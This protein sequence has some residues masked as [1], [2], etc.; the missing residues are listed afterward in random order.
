M[1][2][3]WQILSLFII[4]KVISSNL[5]TKA[6]KKLRNGNLPVEVEKKE[7]CRFSAKNEGFSQ[8][9]IIAYP[10]QNLNTSKG[11]V[12]SQELSL[13]PLE[14]I[15][16]ELKPQGVTDVERV[17]IKRDNKIIHANTY[18]MTFELSVFPLKIKI[19]YTMESVE[20]FIPQSS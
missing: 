3:H 9:K 10:H 15:K 7:A 1:I 8:Q 20:Q 6:N 12:R 5:Q 13:G 16:K 19:G 4:E 11:V 17:L 18:I 14:E 2:L